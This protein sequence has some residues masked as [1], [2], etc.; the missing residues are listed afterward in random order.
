ML[1]LMIVSVAGLVIHSILESGL[2]RGPEIVVAMPGVK[3]CPSCGVENP[4]DA[5]YCHECRYRLK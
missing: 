1:S 4:L 2:K 5:E 3:L